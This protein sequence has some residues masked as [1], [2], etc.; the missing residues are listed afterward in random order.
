MCTAGQQPAAESLEMLLSRQRFPRASE[1]A[2]VGLQFP[3]MSQAEP[4]RR[5]SCLKAK[6]PTPI[7]AATAAAFS[8]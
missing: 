6:K 3:P 4:V 7:T 5:V 2:L 1:P 8:E